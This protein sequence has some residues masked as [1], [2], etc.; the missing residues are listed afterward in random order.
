MKISLFASAIR[1]NLWDSCLNSLLG[2]T[3][4]Y[5][6]VFAGPTPTEEVSKFLNKYPALRYIS[7]GDIK[8]AQ[9]YE[10]ARR[11]C[12]GELICWMADDCEFSEGLLDDIYYFYNEDSKYSV[13]EP[14]EYYKKVISVRTN[15]DEKSN[16]LNDHRFFGWNVNTPLMAPLGFMSRSYLEHLGGIDQRYVC[17]QYENDIVM[18]VYA[19]GGE[20]VKF[21]EG[22][23]K[24]DHLK[25][26]GKETKFWTGYDDDRKVLEGSWVIGGWE[27]Q[28][29][30]FI[31]YGIPP[32]F[33]TPI[34]NREVTFH[35]I[36]KFVPFEDKDLLT[37]SQGQKGIWE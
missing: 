22:C 19:D 7:T 26:H 11:A 2:N 13:T 37:K 34:I 15:E 8:P 28:P 3:I 17:G 5:E 29:K 24:I 10:I 27:E 12:Q 18:R 1:P 20:V 30:Q 14:G 32:Y 35:R 9:C 21:E 4:D 16:N 25:K 23:V 36:D 33:Y 31:V 6:V